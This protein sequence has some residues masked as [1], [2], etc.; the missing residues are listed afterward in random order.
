MLCL[1]SIFVIKVHYK[2][3]QEAKA[4]HLSSQVS[5]YDREV[6]AEALAVVGHITSAETNVVLAAVG[7]M[8][9][10]LGSGAFSLTGNIF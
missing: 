8:F 5:D 1:Y 9:T 2:L 7:L 6:L 10:L 3:S 4:G